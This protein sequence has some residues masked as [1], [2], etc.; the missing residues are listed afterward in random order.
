MRIANYCNGDEVKIIELFEIVFNQKMSIEQ[1]NW[2]FQENPAGRHFIKLMWDNDILVGH[3]AVTPIF[4]Q[5]NGREYLT[6]QSL[7]TMTHPAY[8]GK[9]VFKT[10]ANALYYDLE[11]KHGLY[12]VWGFPNTNSHY[13]FINSLGWNDM[14]VVHTLSRPNTVI[15]NDQAISFKEIYSLSS[16]ICDL[17]QEESFA[18]TVSVSKSKNYLKWRYESKPSVSYR[19]FYAKKNGSTNVLVTK[20]YKQD[21]YNYIVNICDVVVQDF[22]ILPQMLSEISLAY[23]ENISEF[24]IWQNLHTL[25][26]RQ[27]E[28]IGFKPVQPITYLGALKMNDVPT[29]FVDFRNWSFS[30]GDSDVF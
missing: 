9:G 30:M 12:A 6:A 24:T 21:D 22:S 11:N 5:I 18:H 26:H 7:T 3:Y 4:I 29:E 16:E 13:G 28:K 20:L 25:A 15:D 10:L 19:F 2:R 23:P 1:W 8:G 27:Y 17:F 14:G